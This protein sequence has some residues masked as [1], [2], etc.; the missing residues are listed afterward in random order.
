MRVRG[1]RVKAW[2]QEQLSTH[3]LNGRQDRVH[4]FPIL[5]TG[6][7]VF[8]DGLMGVILKPSVKD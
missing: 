6:D 7:Q 8:K 3:I 4:P 1:S 5:P 2:W